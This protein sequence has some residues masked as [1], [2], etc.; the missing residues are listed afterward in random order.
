MTDLDPSRS[1][2]QGSDPS[3]SG[4]QGSLGDTP[5]FDEWVEKIA[6]ILR[7]RRHEEAETVGVDSASE[8]PDPTDHSSGKP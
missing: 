6:S 8:A 5:G 3:R 2:E 1:G 4:E 7:L